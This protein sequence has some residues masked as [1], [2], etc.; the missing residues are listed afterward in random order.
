MS[1]GVGVFLFII[2]LDKE[3]FLELELKVGCELDILKVTREKI[4]KILAKNLDLH[5]DL[6]KSIKII[7]KAR[8]RS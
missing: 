4:K 6:K 7:K 1:V 3:C 2:E 5:L 8:P